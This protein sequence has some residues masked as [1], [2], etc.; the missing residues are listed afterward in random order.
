[1]KEKDFSS[2]SIE[3]VRKY[4][5]KIKV[6]ISGYT[7]N[8]NNKLSLRLNYLKLRKLT[9]CSQMVED[10]TFSFLSQGAVHL[11]K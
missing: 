8:N 2:K 10:L 1:M 3:D 7:K 6:Y 11:H 4:E 5:K 9:V